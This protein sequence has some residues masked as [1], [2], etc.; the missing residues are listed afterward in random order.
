MAS[1][2][3]TSTPMAHVFFASYARLDNDRKRL[4]N[5]VLDLRERVRSVVG[6]ADASKVGFF[7]TY[8]G[9]STGQD[10][11]K[12]L[13]E[14]ARHARVLV[15]FCSNTYFNSEYCANEFEVFRR[16]LDA[17]GP[18]GDA[19]RVVIPVVWNVSAMPKAVS[20]YQTVD[21]NAGFP[22]DYRLQGLLALQS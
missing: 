5:V 8:D 11:E 4:Q 20:R 10:W 6:A 22:D 1:T 12:T 9:I 19:L 15:C 14:A 3:A 17:L 18:A 21:Q 2:R 7:D 13:G 16:R